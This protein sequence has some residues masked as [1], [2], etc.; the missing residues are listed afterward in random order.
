MVKKPKKSFFHEKMPP[1]RHFYIIQKFNFFDG[2]GRNRELFFSK[3]LKFSR[4]ITR[5][6]ILE[7]L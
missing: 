6:Y 5:Y 3:N 4:A 2:L 7:F 1:S